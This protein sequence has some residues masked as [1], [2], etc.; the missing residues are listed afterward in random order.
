MI[1]LKW[2]RPVQ[3]APNSLPLSFEIPAA[4]KELFS[5]YS[6]KDT[7][8]KYKKQDLKTGYF[9]FYY[10]GRPLSFYLYY[11]DIFYIISCGKDEFFDV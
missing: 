4:F 2:R 9:I 3:R 7:C 1:R 5:S 10:R 6:Y 11:R 8:K